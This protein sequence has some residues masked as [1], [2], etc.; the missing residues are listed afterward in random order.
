M[1][2][3]ATT[4][5][6]DHLT[7]KSYAYYV[8]IVY[9]CIGLCIHD[10][11]TLQWYTTSKSHVQLCAPSCTSQ[12]LWPVMGKISKGRGLYL[13][14][15]FSRSRRVHIQ[16]SVNIIAEDKKLRKPRTQPSHR[17]Q[18]L[19]LLHGIT[20]YVAYDVQYYTIQLHQEVG[21]TDR[22]KRITLIVLIEHF[23]LKIIFPA[24][25]HFHRVHQWINGQPNK[26]IKRHIRIL[27]PFTNIRFIEQQVSSA[28]VK[29]TR[30]K[31]F[32][33]QDLMNIT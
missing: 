15:R 20:W 13:L 18:Q 30:W 19:G 1:N 27:M 29:E 21:P 6:S 8:C 23:E 7:R 3:V 9:V 31:A 26:Q 11:S 33:G 14:P 28:P 32:C 24:D 22:A 25:S 12:I 5:A 2:G 10:A 17:S 16:Q 4:L